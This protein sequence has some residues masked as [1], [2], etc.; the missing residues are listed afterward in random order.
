MRLLLVDGHYYLYRSFF[1]IRGLRNSRGEP[2]N[3]IYGFIKVAST[4]QPA[5]TRRRSEQELKTSG[6]MTL[7]AFPIANSI[8]RSSSPWSS[9]SIST[10]SVAFKI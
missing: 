8:W 3:A 7:L 4:S 6:E 2:T 5:P 10:N 1:A 9:T